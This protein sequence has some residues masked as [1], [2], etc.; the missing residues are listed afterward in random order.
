MHLH[1]MDNE[2]CLKLTVDN[3]TNDSYLPSSNVD[4]CTAQ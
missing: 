1:C 3:N 4:V 2:H